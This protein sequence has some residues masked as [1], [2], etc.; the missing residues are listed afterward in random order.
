MRTDYSA[1]ERLYR[2]HRDKGFAGWS[3]SDRDYREWQADCEA[4]LSRGN[5][6]ASGRLLDLG[7]GAGNM[8]LW[9][10]RR[11]FEAYGIDIAPTAIDWARER[12]QA[13]RVR[14]RFDVGSAVRLSEYEDQFFDFVFDG[15]CLHCII[16][17]DRAVLLRNVR[18]ILRPGGYFLIQTMCGPVVV[19]NLNDEQAAHYDAASRC[20]VYDGAAVRYFAE[21][22]EILGEVSRASLEILRYDL[23]LP[24]PG[25]PNRDLTI[26][27]VR[28]AG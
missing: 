20:V 12:S 21:R 23:P 3:Q 8:T 24:P 4:V 10:A 26:E 7:C 1:H 28:P 15:H 27:A 13:Q 18:R 22:D 17:D 25:Q 19:E 6:P 16:G 11:G 9:F 2:R 5:A 14:A